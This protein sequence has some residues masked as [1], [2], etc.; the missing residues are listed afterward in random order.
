MKI[1]FFFLFINLFF[2][3]ILSQKLSNIRKNNESLNFNTNN[4]FTNDS[5]KS[6][7]KNLTSKKKNL[8]VGAISGY[9]WETIA[10]FFKSLIRSGIQNYDFIIFYRKISEKVINKIKECGIIIHEIDDK[11]KNET[12]IN[13]R[14]K[15]YFDFL[16]ER[17]DEYN[18][19]FASDIRDTIFQKDVFQLYEDK[20]AFLGIAIE[21][22]T[23]Q[24]YYNKNWTIG[25]CGEKLYNTIKHERIICVGTI[26]GTLDKFMEFSDILYQ[27]LSTHPNTIEQG[28][29]NFLFYHDKI[30]NNFILKSDNYGPVMTIALTKRNNI[31]L[32]EQKN[33]LNFENEIASVIHQYDRKPD[34]SEII[35][36]KYC[37][38]LFKDEKEN[39]NFEIGKVKKK[40]NKIINYKLKIKETT[41]D[42]LIINFLIN[43]RNRTFLFVTYLFFVCLFSKFYLSNIICI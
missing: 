41:K 26:W 10:P 21:D 28:V 34:L 13:I 15:I 3:I 25:F 7:M 40:N 33:I 11:Y 18:L 9:S 12:I 14:W 6:N 1:I 20:G 43:K 36:K 22:G 29:A 42:E 2:N 4:I 35:Y 27:T 5:L 31:L 32:D 23:L 37:P 39:D 17:K 30:M 24:E 8:I 16:K 19:I 38:E